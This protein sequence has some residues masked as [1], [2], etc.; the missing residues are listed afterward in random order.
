MPR[1]SRGFLTDFAWSIIYTVIMSILILTSMY[2]LYTDI[3]VP[4]IA[5]CDKY[6]IQFEASK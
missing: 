6:D 5:M 2:I 1:K 3:I 4:Y